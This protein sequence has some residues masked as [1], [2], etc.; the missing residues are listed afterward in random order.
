MA[1]LTPTDDKKLGARNV[2]APKPAQGPAS[3]PNAGSSKYGTNRPA[4][5][6]PSKP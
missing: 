4:P 2:K 6:K 3:L 5:I 1:K